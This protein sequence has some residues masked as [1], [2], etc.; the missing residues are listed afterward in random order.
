MLAAED[1]R[2]TFFPGSPN[3]VRALNNVSL[4]LDPGEFVTVIFFIGSR[5]PP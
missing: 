2:K 3:E 5:R 4:R 1:I